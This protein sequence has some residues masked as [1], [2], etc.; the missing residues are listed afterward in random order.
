MRRLS[1]LVLSFVG[2]AVG[3]LPGSAADLSPQNLPPLAAA[4]SPH[5]W[6]GFYVGALAGGALGASSQGYSASSAFLSANLPS[7]LPFADAAGSQSLGLRGVD[8]G[9]ETGY[10]WKVAS[11]F[12]L[13]VAGDLNWSDLSGSRVTSG[14]LPLVQFPYAI[15]QSL[16]SDW[17]GS[18]RARL[19]VTPVDNILVYATGG[20][21][22]GHF[23]Y[24]SA[25][26]D[27]LTPPFAPGNETEN[28]VFNG[29]RGGWTLGGGAELALSRN[30]SV[31][32]E[33]RFSEY[34]AVSGVGE[35]PLQQ[36]SSTAYIAHSSGLIRTH[37]L[38]AGIEYR[39]D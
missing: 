1:C 9:V 19:G 32:S 10:D 6:T 16:N 38:R 33:Y 39:F 34:S 31:K 24:S 25:F 12:L 30:V 18:L 2:A 15:S 3:A 22:F 35:L 37:A 8:L 14:T 11:R 4:A 26:W 13:G 17:R 5:D 27:Q 20:L 23:K 7:L 28:A 29:W 21:A 36:P